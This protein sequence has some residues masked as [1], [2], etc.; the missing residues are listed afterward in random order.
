[1]ALSAALS[2]IEIEFVDGVLGKDVQDNAIPSKPG[3]NRMSNPVIGCWRGH[4]DAIRMVVQQNLSSVLILEDDADW[5]VRLKEQMR[6]LALA[7]HALTQPLES[8]PTSYADPTYPMPADA[9]SLPGADLSFEDLPKTVPPRDS[10]YGDNWDFIWVGQCGMRF[11]TPK[12]MIPK[13]R[14]VMNDITVPEK[15]HLN[16]ITRPDPLKNQYP[17]HTRVVHHVSEGICSLGYAITQAGA[18]R[19]LHDIGLFDV[20]TPYDILLRQFCEGSGGRKYH[21]CLTMQPSIFNH[22]RPA[23]LKTAESDISDHGK[24]YREKAVTGNVRWSMRMNWD[25]LLDGK[26]DFEDQWPDTITG[27]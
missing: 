3:K 18:R 8:D 19:L 24:E 4:M 7:S 13:C 27:V 16:T 6:D 12:Q 15:H 26:T 1:M 11:P 2:N 22:H 23:G 10:P 5:D 25:I 20:T 17:D 9:A 14:V 21:N